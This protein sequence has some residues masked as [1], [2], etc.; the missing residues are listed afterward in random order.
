[1]FDVVLVAELIINWTN[2]TLVSGM[3]NDPYGIIDVRKDLGSADYITMTTVGATVS[4]LLEWH[5]LLVISLQWRHNEPHGVSNHQPHESLLNRLFRRRSDKTSKL[6]VTGLCVGNS[7][8]TGEFP[9]QRASNAER[10]SIWWRHHVFQRSTVAT[11]YSAMKRLNKWKCLIWRKHTT[12]K[13]A[14]GTQYTHAS[15]VNDTHDS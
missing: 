12:C 7:P 11:I 15:V 4:Q 3:R 8:V 1:M 5:R 14:N 13:S 9:A 10:F 6:R 2:N